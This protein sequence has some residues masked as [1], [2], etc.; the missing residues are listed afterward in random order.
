MQ[1]GKWPMPI[2]LSHHSQSLT[3]TTSK[4]QLEHLCPKTWVWRPAARHFTHTAF[5]SAIFS[6]S[7]CFC[8]VT[9]VVWVPK[10]GTEECWMSMKCRTCPHAGH[11]GILTIPFP[12]SFRVAMLLLHTHRRR[13]KQDKTQVGIFERQSHGVIRITH[14]NQQLHV[15]LQL[16]GDSMSDFNLKQGST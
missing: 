11:T 13:D 8:L 7:F 12:I 15:R 4:G 10:H 16:E 14:H 9:R 1:G 5:T 3:Y 2:Q 6:P